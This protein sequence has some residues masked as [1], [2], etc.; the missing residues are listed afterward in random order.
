MS[1]LSPGDVEFVG[2]SNRPITADAILI[3]G[4]KARTELTFRRAVDVFESIIQT[5][6]VFAGS[7]QGL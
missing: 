3:K 4:Q 2:K 1:S 7:S 5:D 6:S